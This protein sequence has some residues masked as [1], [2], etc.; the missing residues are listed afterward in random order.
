VN[1]YYIYA[2]P[3]GEDIYCWLSNNY[4]GPA[5]NLSAVGKLSFVYIV[6][7]LLTILSF[8]AVTELSLGDTFSF[9][10]SFDYYPLKVGASDKVISA[11]TT[12]GFGSITPSI[13][14][15]PYPNGPLMYTYFKPTVYWYG[16][17]TCSGAGTITFQA[18]SKFHLIEKEILKFLF[19]FRCSDNSTNRWKPT[20]C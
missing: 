11:I 18:E 16:I 17:M 10:C 20:Q 14:I 19:Y 6:N 1:R 4:D 5:L 8:L 12:G 9:D 3:G 15:T 2:Q 13:G 7:S